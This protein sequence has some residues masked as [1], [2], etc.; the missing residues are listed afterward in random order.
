[1]STLAPAR[2]L[3][4]GPRAPASVQVARWTLAPASFL[5][6]CRRRFGDLFTLRLVLGGRVP[7]VFLADPECVG[8][9]FRR[10]A[11]T[12]GLPRETL[13]PIFG[14]NSV[15]VVDGPEHMRKRKLLAP[16][17][18]GE[19]MKRYER[20]VLDATTAA[21]E[22]WPVGEPIALSGR[23]HSI[24]L[25]V[26]FKAVFGLDDERRDAL[27]RRR[28]AALLA[29]GANRFTI[30]AA[31]LPARVGP[32]GLRFPVVHRRRRLDAALHEE[33]ARR[34]AEGDLAGRRDVMSTLL[35][36]RDETGDGL[37]DQEVCDNLVTIL[38]AGHETTATAVAWS[39]D[40]LL[41]NPA[42]YER[43]VEEA[44]DPAGSGEYADAV[45]TETLRLSPPLPIV[46][47]A[48]AAP[49]RAGG[50]E[51]PAGTLVAPCSFLIHRSPE[52]FAPDPEA[53]RPERFLDAPVDRSSWFPF[54]GGERRCLGANFAR[55]QARL[56]V[57][58]VLQLVD[59]SP[60]AARAETI[61][62]QGLVLAPRRGTR[63]V[64]LRQL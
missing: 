33:I 6:D 2:S 22:R 59:L 51:L 18:H 23:L 54:G 31:A 43:L 48:L 30:A 29:L 10:N 8:E 3:P 13:T 35:T 38:L 4:P 56:I 36:A 14:S 53:F 1:V 46:T 19:N 61:R 21:V 27:M 37:S 60:A 12:V 41:H 52:L 57:T 32:V 20:T 26:V 16:P 17:F 9:V 45:I 50:H 15:L 7:T 64:V 40:H 25:E 62:R 24:A 42:A 63:A 55:V 34:R 28:I 47:R 58:R 5:R 44:R 39:F 11:T 49:L